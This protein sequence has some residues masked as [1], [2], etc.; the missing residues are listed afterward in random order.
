MAL[1]WPLHLG[2]SCTRGMMLVLIAFFAIFFHTC[3]A[4]AE[5]IQSGYVTDPSLS[6]T[7]EDLRHSTL[8]PFNNFLALGYGGPLWVKLR[9]DPGSSN[10]AETSQP[11]F[12]RIRPSYLDE[13]V[14]Y[15]S[16]GDQLAI[17]GDRHPM[18][19]QDEPS[20]MMI[21]R[22]PENADPYDIWIRLSTTS[23]RNSYFEVLDERSMRAS[24]SR[25]EIGGALYLGAVS[26]LC[27]WAGL[28]L[29]FRRDRLLMCFM[30]YNLQAIIL[31]VCLLG[32]PRLYAPAWI[33]IE[34]VDTLTS[35]LSLTSTGTAIFFAVLLLQT[36]N[37]PAWHHR[38]LTWICALYP[39]LVTG[40]FIGYDREALQINMILILMV[41]VVN[42]LISAISVNRPGYLP[43]GD[44]GLPPLLTVT[45]FG[46]SCAFTL[47][48]AIPNLGLSE[49]SAFS[50]Y[51][52]LLYCLCTGVLMMSILKYRQYR[53]LLMQGAAER[54]AEH[55]KLQASDERR[56]RMER[57]AMLDVLSH[58]LRT[59]LSSILMLSARET[60]AQDISDRIRSVVKEMTMVV[61]RAF[62]STRFD[63]SVQSRDD[64]VNLRELA[65]D[66]AK[67]LPDSQRIV[68]QHNSQISDVDLIV[69]VDPA[70]ARIIVKNLLENALKYSPDF[71]VVHMGVHDIFTRDTCSFSVWNQPGRAGWPDPTAVFERYYRSEMAAHQKGCGLGLH[72]AR[73]WARRLGGDLL[74]LPDDGRIR[75][76]FL[77]KRSPHGF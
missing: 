24:N 17:F 11:L 2:A 65:F 38:W 28:Q 73:G 23:T 26:F 20:S 37:W 8:T 56:L 48:R 27:L 30:A 33:K 21:W 52:V 53:M 25:I 18:T 4:R 34:W 59:P 69:K 76:Q 15:D 63:D 36:M 51:I 41:P 50:L 29:L 43:T 57:E 9:I 14:I 35:L 47:M 46:V 71:S 62:S 42:F 45:Y 64:T 1:P 61:D 31:G 40:L 72:L 44:G 66:V 12:L 6:L 3:Q 75:F 77:I 70:I 68:W 7:V 13:L 74:F 22:M 16:E 19:A 55:Q 39:A 10:V 67:N 60:I 54:E 58:E 32:Y 49:G 5:I